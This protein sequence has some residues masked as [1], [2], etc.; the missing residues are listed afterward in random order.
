M[1]KSLSFN[2]TSSEFNE[3]MNMHFP[4]YLT[5]AFV[6]FNETGSYEK[7]SKIF[8]RTFTGAGLCYTFNM[9][10]NKDMFNSKI[11]DSF[12]NHN[13]VKYKESYE[14]RHAISSGRNTGLK[15]H[16]DEKNFKLC[17][18][19]PGFSVHLHSPYDY[20]KLN[21]KAIL[22]SYNSFSQ[23]TVIPKVKYTSDKLI[24]YDT[25]IRQCYFAHERPLKFFKIYTYSNCE[26]EC[27]LE[28][29][30]RRCKCVK[31]YLPND[32]STR[33]YQTER[34][35]SC[36]IKSF[37]RLQT[38]VKKCDC[39]PACSEVQYDYEFNDIATGNSR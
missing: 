8:R 24:K 1:I 17:Q 38:R 2:A 32:N 7:A 13:D 29:A 9:L 26:L 10:E 11:A 37:F 28:T 21:K 39:L 5:Q 22:V 35:F 23:I 18:W 34:E 14:L 33:I 30:L 19:S 12:I 36:H 6:S 27:E 16:V 20:P 15:V 3:N 4:S 25:N 31:F